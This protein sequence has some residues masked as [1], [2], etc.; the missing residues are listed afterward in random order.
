MEKLGDRSRPEVHRDELLKE[1]LPFWTAHASPHVSEASEEGENKGNAPLG[2]SFYLD[3][4]GLVV[5]TDRSV[6]LQCR[7]VYFAC[8]LL[9]D[10]VFR[11]FLPTESL[12]PQ[13]REKKTEDG[14]RSPLLTLD[15]AVIHE[16]ALLDTLRLA[17]ECLRFVRAFG[18]VPGDSLSDARLDGK[19]FF[20]VTATGEGVV[21]RRYVFTECFGA[22][23]FGAFGMLCSDLANMQD[24]ELVGPA[25][26]RETVRQLA[27]DAMTILG[28]GTAQEA[29]QAA[30]EATRVAAKLWDLIIRLHTT[31]DAK[32]LPPKETGVRPSKSLAMP[33]ILIWVAQVLREV[34]TMSQDD[35]FRFD[36]VIESSINEIRTDFCHPEFK[37]VLESVARD[38]S[39]IDTPAGRAINPGHSLECAWF[40]LLEAR[41]RRDREMLQL[42]LQIVD[43][44]WGWGWDES[45]GGI[46][47]FRDAK[48]LPP[49]EYWHDMK[50]WWPSN[51]AIIATLMAYSLT[52][53]DRYA[54][55]HKL[56]FEWA[57]DHFRG[58][59][60]AVSFVVL[61]MCS[62][63]TRTFSSR[64]QIWRLRRMWW[65]VVRPVATRR[66]SLLAG[67][68]HVL[69]RCFSQSQTTP[70]LLAASP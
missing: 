60:P 64:P 30:L 11:F 41:E 19:M 42:G 29:R 8:A 6:W 61:C 28:L 49:P 63:L 10:A 4:K 44:S 17:H 39:F 56:A 48:N 53:D 47:Y 55:M 7:C 16:S 46:I 20:R 27:T 15:E 33:M 68:R 3:R 69:E 32:L 57:W 31:D 13:G 66:R 36:E 35:V 50:F 9:R 70:C 58:T 25:H 5:D 52:G 24:T 26:L 38:G 21:N 65:R 23:C 43:W 12:R 18:F 37:A 22:A 45:F 67:E 1:I 62:V 51:E 59:D 54:A 14:E 40:I 2:G 34:P